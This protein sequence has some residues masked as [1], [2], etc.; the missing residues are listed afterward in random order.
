MKSVKNFDYKQ[1]TSITKIQEQ[2]KLTIITWKIKN[3]V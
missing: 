1:T 2:N 3:N